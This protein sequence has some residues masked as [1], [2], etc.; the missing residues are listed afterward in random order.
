MTFVDQF[1]NKSAGELIRAELWNKLMSAL[2]DLATSVNTQLATLESEVTTLTTSVGQLQTD[3]GTISGE[4]TQYFKVSLST[5]RVTYATGEEATIAAQVTDLAGNTVAFTDETRPWIDFVAV[6]G[7]LRAADG[8]ESQTGD[9][10][11]GDRAVSIRTNAQGL[12]QALLRAEVGPELPLEVH[13]DV[14]ATLTAKLTDQRTIS[15]AILD[16]PT[17]SDAKNAG[18]FAAFTA[19]YDRPAAKNVRSYLDTYY[20]HQAPSVIGKIAPPIVGP[21]WRDYASIVVALARADSDPTTPDR[22]RG[23]AAIRVGFRDWVAPWLLLHYF[24]PD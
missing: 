9:S 23:A 19:E 22:A 16:A 4:L 14:G 7:H 13:A 1:G 20:I 5:T 24:P 3:V 11:G 6:W 18:A 21:R 12:A 2:D 17:P 8:F 15:Q 10:S